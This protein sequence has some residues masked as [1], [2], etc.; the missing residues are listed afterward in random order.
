M[1]QS[2]R[3]HHHLS[4][5]D[6]SYLAER[7]ASSNLPRTA[8]EL[9]LPR[10]TIAVLLVPEAGVSAGTAA[11]ARERIAASRVAASTPST[12]PRAA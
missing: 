10:Q 7:V 2:T 3:R 6:R 5:A 8:R 4:D 9:G 11:L 1:S 12:P